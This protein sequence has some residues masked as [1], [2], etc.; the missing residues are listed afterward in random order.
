MDL[1]PLVKKSGSK[2]SVGIMMSGSGTNAVKIIEYARDNSSCD[3]R[4]DLIFSDNPDSNAKKIGKEYNI[5][6]E[7]FD[8]EKFY[9]DNKDLKRF[10][11]EDRPVYDKEVAKILSK[12]NIEV[13]AYA[14]Y[15]NITTE[16]IISKFL[17]INVHP[18]DLSIKTDAG[19]RKYV[20]AH[21]VIDAIKAGEET[22]ASTT[23]IITQG[24]DEGPLLMISTPIEVEVP[25][26][27][28]F[29]NEEKLTKIVDKNQERLKEQ[30]DW[31]IFPK[32]LDFIAKGKILTDKE[33]NLHY[34]QKPIPEGI[35]S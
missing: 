16:P 21:A 15:M 26:E 10:S 20:G 5:P 7:I 28:D 17:G 35:K 24:V 33:G 19:E 12:Y 1:K 4:V 31:V 34:N 14:G 29:S 27:I 3:Y 18:A 23:H 22:I 8:V 6:V 11:L 30:G 2:L 25:S 32:T 13:L 9:Q